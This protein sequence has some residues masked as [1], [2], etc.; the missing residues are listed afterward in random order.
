M[1]A[2]TQQLK[3]AVVRLP[4]HDR[5]E[6]AEALIASFATGAEVEAYWDVEVERR[7]EEVQRG[8]V[9]GIPA[10]EAIRMLR[11]KLRAGRKKEKKEKKDPWEKERT[12]AFFENENEI[13]PDDEMIL[14]ARA[15]V[16]RRAI[17]RGKL[18]PEPE[19]VSRYAEP[20]REPL[21]AGRR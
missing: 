21:E 19:D 9:K 10:E 4:F 3:K 7:W 13:F 16:R 11:K 8:E 17:A 5:Q 2:T 18:D 1:K 12:E 15:R 20:S 6:I 14:K